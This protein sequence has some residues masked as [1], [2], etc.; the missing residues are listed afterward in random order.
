M[1]PWLL[2]SGNLV[3]ILRPKAA[4][5]AI[6]R[7]SAVSAFSGLIGMGIISAAM[8]LFAVPA[9]LALRSESPAAL[10]AG[11]GILGVLGAWAY[12]KAVPREARLLADRRDEFLPT[13][14][15]DDA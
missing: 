9:L 10:L 1:A 3:S 4:S 6:Q 2:L 8:G 14:C 15:G 11:W 12:R 7:S 5:F 13:I